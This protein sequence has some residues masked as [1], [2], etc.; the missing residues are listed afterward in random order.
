MIFTDKMI[1]QQW[2]YIQFSTLVRLCPIPNN[3]AIRNS[4]RINHTEICKNPQN[5]MDLTGKAFLI[6]TISASS[7][8]LDIT[9]YNRQTPYESHQF[10]FLNFQ[11]NVCKPLSEQVYR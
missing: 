4:A 7:Q 8:N 11:N 2:I 3:R 1:S 5:K 6:D 9:S 10:G